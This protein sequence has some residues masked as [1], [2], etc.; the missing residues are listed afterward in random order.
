MCTASIESLREQVLYRLAVLHHP[1]G[2]RYSLA[3]TILTIK[4]TTPSTICLALCAFML[5]LSITLLAGR[6]THLARPVTTVF[7]LPENPSI[8]QGFKHK[9]LLIFIIFFIKIIYHFNSIPFVFL[10]LT[11]NTYLF[12][13]LKS[14]KLFYLTQY[15]TYDLICLALLV[16]FLLARKTI[17]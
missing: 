10:L 11:T 17:L 8:N 16:D 12:V 1:F 15:L 13:L 5:K 14:L 2:S 4:F 9:L 6:L 7:H 3:S